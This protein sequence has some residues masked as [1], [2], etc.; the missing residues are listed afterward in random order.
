MN[1]FQCN[2]FQN[3]ECSL[4][5]LNSPSDSLSDEDRLSTF[6]NLHTEEDSDLVSKAPY[7]NMNM[8]DDLPLLMSD[9]LMWNSNEKSRSSPD[10]SSSLAQLLCSSINKHSRSNDHGGG[11]IS[12]DHMMEIDSYY[13]KKSTEIVSFVENILHS[14]VFRFLAKWKVI[15]SCV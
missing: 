12:P 4:P 2:V 10:S 6:M 7:I 1:D 15:A 3:S 5:S 8:A 11:L 14:I 9:D 13:N